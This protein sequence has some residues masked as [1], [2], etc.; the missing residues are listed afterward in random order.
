MNATTKKLLKIGAGVLTVAATTVLAIIGEKN[1][2]GYFL[3]NAKDE[4]LE[5]E[6]EKVRLDFC[7][8]NLDTDYRINCQKVLGMF[9]RE[10][11]KRAWGN[12]KPHAP[13][14]HSEHGWYLSSDD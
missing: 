2:F 1:S 3:R 6:R 9:D 10:M 4:E 8:P 14:Y 7:N 12:E 13:S 5:T 11:S